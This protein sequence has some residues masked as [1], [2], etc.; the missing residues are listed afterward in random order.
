M[1]MARRW[2]LVGT[3]AVSLAVL[4]GCSE[5]EL[6]WVDDFSDPTSGWL[7]ESD[8]SAEVEY[9]EG[10]MRIL[11]KTPNG[12]AW[13]SAER[14]F[15][16]FHL[17]VEATQFAG[18]D[19]NE[20]GVLVRMQDSD[21][22]YRFSISGD[23]YYLVSKYDGEAWEALSGDDWLPGDAIHLGAA[24]NLL[25][26]MCHGATMTFVVNDVQL[27]EVRDS[28]YSRGDIG[29]YAGSFFQPGV[30]IHFDN[31]AITAP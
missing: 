17:S 1:G 19:D 4:V 8:A 30:E 29:L 22:F 13:A 28:S 26:I 3:V 10:V 23:G 5:G 2:W 25:E 16:D 6:P 12:L 21:R 27:A 31:F 20:Y 18:P 24:T 7:A 9:D 11:V 15:S 14:E